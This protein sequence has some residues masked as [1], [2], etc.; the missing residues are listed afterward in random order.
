MVIM[1]LLGAAATAAAVCSTTAAVFV[2]VDSCHRLRPER[3]VARGKGAGVNGAITY[4]LT[5]VSF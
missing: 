5:Q 4:A 1:F 3:L 2:A